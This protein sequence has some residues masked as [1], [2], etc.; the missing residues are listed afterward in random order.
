MNAGNDPVF[1]AHLGEALIESGRYEEAETRLAGFVRKAS[2]S[3]KIREMLEIAC[4]KS[5]GSDQGFE[6][7]L[8]E[9]EQEA[10]SGI[11]AEL[12]ERLI[13]MTAPEFGPE[14]PEGHTVLLTGLRGKTLRLDEYLPSGRPKNPCF[15]L[16]HEERDREQQNAH[17]TDDPRHSDHG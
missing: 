10:L 6:A 4:A 13:D 3:Q 9:V 11:T 14:D 8:E 12:K 2:A 15:L 5:T 7:F 1:N 16:S 17:D